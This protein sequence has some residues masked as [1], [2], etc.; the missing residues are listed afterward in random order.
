VCDVFVID[1]YRGQGLGKW[2][3]ET[4]VT[5]PDFAKIRRFMLATRD[6]HDL[7][8]Q[9]GFQSLSAP[10]RWMERFNKDA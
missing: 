7:Y 5:H 8:K 4:I 9:S 1:A 10:E 3:M 2:L 6:A